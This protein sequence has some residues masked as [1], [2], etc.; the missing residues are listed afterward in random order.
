MAA[1]LLTTGAPTSAR[2]PERRSGTTRFVEGSE[3]GSAGT[4]AVAELPERYPDFRDPRLV[5]S[6]TDGYDVV[7]VPALASAFAASRPVLFFEYD[8]GLSRAAG[9]DPGLVWPA[10]A[11]LGYETVSVWDNLGA[12]IGSR[13]VA[14]L[15]TQPDVGVLTGDRAPYWDVAVAHRDDPAGT[16]AVRSSLGAGHP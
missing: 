5:K 3:D 15:A 11:A 12:P 7:L 4:L 13:T 6:D 14:E 10:L 9:N 2:V 8:L 16:A 1:G